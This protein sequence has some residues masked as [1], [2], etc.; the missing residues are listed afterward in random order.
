MSDHFKRSLKLLG[1][2]AAIL[3]G[4]Y[5]W[6]THRLSGS[7]AT[8]GPQ[9]VLPKGIKEQVTYNDKTHKV[10][11]TTEKGTT[12]TYSR[13][14]TIEVKD[15]GTL[16][17]NAHIWGLERRY[18]GGLGY[19][20]GPRGY[21]GMQFFYWHQ[22]DLSGAVGI[23][24]DKNRRALQLV[25]GPSWNPYSNTSLHLAVNL[26]PMATSQPPQVGAFVSIRF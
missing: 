5:F 10:R 3:L 18:F 17:V 20:D 19:C 23:T 21:V 12:Y 2:I 22:F 13:D 24:T 16:A 14:P 6:L 25:V 26:V 11:I 15:D 9:V 8:A 7:A 1:L 4:V